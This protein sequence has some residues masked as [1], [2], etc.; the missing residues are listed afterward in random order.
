MRE[1]R[2]LPGQKFNRSALVR[3]IR[4][5]SQI[6]YFDPENIEPDM[7]PNFEEATVD[8]VFKLEERPNDQIELS[9]GWGGLFGFVGTVG[10]SFNNFSIRNIKD[11]S[12]W[13]PLPVGDGQKLS[14]RVQANGRSFQNY[15]ISFSEPWFGG[16]KPNALSVSFNHSVQRQIDMWNRANFGREMGSFK[17]TGATI[18]LAKRVTWPDDYFQV[19]NNLQFQVYDFDEYGNFFGLSYNTGTARSIALNTTIARN[20][21]DNPIYPRLGSN[22][23]LSS[24]FTPPYASMNPNINRESPDEKKY[25]W[26][27]YHKWMFDASLYTPLFGSNKLVL[28]ARTHMGFVGFYGDRIGIMAGKEVNDALVPIGLCRDGAVDEE[29]DGRGVGIS[30][31]RRQ[32]DRLARIGFVPSPAMGQERIVAIGPEMGIE[33]LGALG[34]ADFDHGAPAA[35]ERFFEELRQ[36]DLEGPGFEMIE[37]HFG[38]RSSRWSDAL[39]PYAF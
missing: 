3:T 11:F 35:L 4:E 31:V 30:T 21:I 16:K 13:R 5:L 32:Q 27:E 22:I 8:I 18:G 26:L 24:S 20:N 15:S 37:Q 34:A 7:R 17:I 19:S 1:I 39:K 2:I 14:L 25:Q 9:G 33:G 36:H 10:L 23:I 12:K 38:H 6:G 29:A 28:S